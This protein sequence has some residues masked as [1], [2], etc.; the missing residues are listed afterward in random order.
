DQIVFLLVS[1]IF[2]PLLSH[3][4]G[5]VIL[6][7]RKH[8]LALQVIQSSGPLECSVV[9][10]IGWTSTRLNHV[11]EQCLETVDLIMTPKTQMDVEALNGLVLDMTHI[12]AREGERLGSHGFVLVSHNQQ[13]QATRTH[14]DVFTI[15]GIVPALMLEEVLARADRPSH[16][17][18]IMEYARQ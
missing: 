15:G 5:Q 18:P 13:S 9:L 12:I 1:S 7:Q 11:P 14:P 4:V 3:A 8:I 10:P 17:T 2:P 6:W 16:T